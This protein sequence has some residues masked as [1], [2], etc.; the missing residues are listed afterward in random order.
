M[1]DLLHRLRELPPELWLSLRVTLKLAAV[2]TLLLLV[3]AT[4][5]AWWLART[6]HWLAVVVEALVGLPIVLPPTVLGFYLLALFS[7][8][9]WA[10]Q[11]WFRTTGGTLAFSFSGL[12][13]GSMLYSLPFAVQPILAAFR[14]VR[15]SYLDAS[16]SLGGSNVTTF[17][18]IALPL[19]RR[20]L[21][22]AAALSFAHTLGEFGIVMML[23]GS[24]PG[25]TKVASIALY[26][27][28][29]RL[30]Y[31]SAHAFAAVLLLLSFALL[32]PLTILQRRTPAEA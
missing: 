5:L 31:A 7:P 15:R 10:G 6:R 28:V 20:G 21:L 30:D 27:E 13:L 3:L 16:V 23:G 26:D 11:L 19:A 32:L 25:K 17:R 4:P 29:Q 18:R 12:V 1:T 8:G 2:V 24:I 22:V 9:S 14:S